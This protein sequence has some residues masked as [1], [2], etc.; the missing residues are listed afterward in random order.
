MRDIELP[1]KFDKGLPERCLFDLVNEWMSENHENYYQI[2][3][4]R[5]RFT[6]DLNNDNK[7]TD[8]LVI[9]NFCTDYENCQWF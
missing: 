7:A 2:S 8:S 6:Q 4:V 1:G 3:N 5:I 9:M